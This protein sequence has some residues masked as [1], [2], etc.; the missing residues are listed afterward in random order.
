[1]IG[2]IYFTQN[3]IHNCNSLQIT[4]AAPY[5]KSF[6]LWKGVLA[7]EGVC[8]PTC[9]SGP[10]WRR[11]Q[12]ILVQL[13]LGDMNSSHGIFHCYT[14]TLTT[15]VNAANRTVVC[16][17]S[18]E[19]ISSLSLPSRHQPRR[20]VSLV[21][22]WHLPK[23]CQCT[24]HI[25]RLRDETRCLRFHWRICLNP[26]MHFALHRIMWTTFTP[27]AVHQRCCQ[28]HFKMDW[29]VLLGQG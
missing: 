9:L 24:L 26:L 22:P 8:T 21:T 2:S 15:I 23:P 17:I 18:E 29:T 4:L 13:D 27:C 5:N 28:R 19:F 3:A 1:M 25:T 11:V 12:R 7:P 10:S 14:Y 16:I 6:E 20:T